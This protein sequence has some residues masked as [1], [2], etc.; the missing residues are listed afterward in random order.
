MN[1]QEQFQIIID[2]LFNASTVGL[3]L[4]LLLIFLRKKK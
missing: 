4:G 2:V 1:P 3:A